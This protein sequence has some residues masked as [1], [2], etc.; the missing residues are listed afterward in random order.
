MAVFG[1]QGGVS[2]LTTKGDLYT[3]STT[4]AKLPVGADGK[5]L[6][7]ASAQTTGLLWI[8]AAVPVGGLVKSALTQTFA[9]TTSSSTAVNDDTIPQLSEC[10]VHANLTTNYA[11][12]TTGNKLRFTV[13]VNISGSGANYMV[14]AMFIDAATSASAA[15][16]MI[17]DMG[18]SNN[19]YSWTMQFE[20]TAADTSAHDYK[21]GLGSVGGLTLTLNGRAG[22]RILGGVMVSSVKIEEIRV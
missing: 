16:M 13:N 7:A 3:F 20:L 9:M 8:D 4:D 1:P 10:T 5:I 22:A 6:S 2:P 17:N 11:A 19:P 15:Q 14:L 21:I 12:S 18:T